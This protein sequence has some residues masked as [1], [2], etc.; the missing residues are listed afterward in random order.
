MQRFVNFKLSKGNYFKDTDGN[1]VLDLNAAQAGL[2]LGYNSD[3]LVNARTTDL[4]DR[5]VTHKVDANSLP[6]SDFADLLRELVMPAAPSGMV[7]VHLG[8]GSTG[9]E[10]NELA[11]AVA[12]RHFA[13]AHN[14]EVG[15]LC[16]LGFDNSNHG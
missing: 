8:G 12:L 2:I 6:P 16:V 13:K 4:Y 14:A 5:F 9:A 1:T 7:Q 15:S 11:L 3:D 10:A